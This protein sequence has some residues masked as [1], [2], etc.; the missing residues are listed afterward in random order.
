M[1]VCL[2]NAWYRVGLQKVT[3]LLNSIGGPR[4]HRVAHPPEQ[5]ADAYGSETARPR[6]IAGV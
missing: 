5:R 3:T 1:S 2:T 4:H 6:R